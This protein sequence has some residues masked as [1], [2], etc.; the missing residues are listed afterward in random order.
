MTVSTLNFLLNNSAA[1]HWTEP[2]STL[3]R[4]ILVGSLS[5]KLL[6]L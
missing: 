3:R 6:I 1:P 4:T 2:R 5:I